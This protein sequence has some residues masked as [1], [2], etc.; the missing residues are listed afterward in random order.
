MRT[1][2]RVERRDESASGPRG[3]ILDRGAGDDDL[4]HAGAPRARE[5]LVETR[6]ERRVREVGADVDELHARSIR[7]RYKALRF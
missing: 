7:D 2:R 3:A 4:R 6:G 5:H 1:S